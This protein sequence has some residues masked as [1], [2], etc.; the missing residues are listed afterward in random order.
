MSHAELSAAKINFARQFFIYGQLEKAF[1][2]G[3]EDIEDWFTWDCDIAG[4]SHTS[5][6]ASFV[7]DFLLNG[8]QRICTIPFKNIVMEGYG[9]VFIEKMP[10]MLWLMSHY[11]RLKVARSY[12]VLL[13]GFDRYRTSR[14]DILRFYLANACSFNDLYIELFNSL[15]NRALPQNMTIA[16]SDITNASARV[17]IKHSMLKAT[18]EEQ[19]LK[20]TTSSNGQGETRTEEN[21]CNSITSRAEAV[22]IRVWLQSHMTR[23][24]AIQTPPSQRTEGTMRWENMDKISG[25]VERGRNITNGTVIPD[26]I[27]YLKKMKDEQRRSRE[28]EYMTKY[29]RI[30]MNTEITI[31]FLKVGIAAKGEIVKQI[32]A[33]SKSPMKE[34]CVSRVL[35]H[36]ETYKHFKTLVTLHDLNGNNQ[37]T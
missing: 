19:N 21:K 35:H 26:Y 30:F 7:Y 16:T 3:K 29:Q 23:L 33:G 9:Q 4:Y 10:Y 24:K 37:Q 14:P 11:K 36:Y 28:A 5:W 32:K 12:L 34:F 17:V 20:T 27:K 1:K 8:V 15:V 31:G 22:R 25:M 18:R 13:R 6:T 2:D